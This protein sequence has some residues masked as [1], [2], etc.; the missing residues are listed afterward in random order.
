MLPT[1]RDAYLET[2]VLTA[3]PQRLR[4]MLIEG[5]IRKI[6]TA[7]AAHEAGDWLKASEDLGRCRDIV[8]ELISGIDPEQTPVARQILGVYMFIYSTIVECEF[9]LDRGRLPELLRVLEEER[10]TWRAV[11]EQMPDRPTPASDTTQKSEELAPQRVA[12]NWSGGYVPAPSM[13]QQRESAFTLD[14]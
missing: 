14:A 13:Y 9:G 7:Q 3:T 5:A 8:S 12:D 6:T 1:P 10:Q 2:Q 4:L 11:C